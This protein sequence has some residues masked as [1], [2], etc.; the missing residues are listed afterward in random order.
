MKILEQ[1]VLVE[2][3]SSTTA[4][5]RNCFCRLCLV[6]RRKRVC[7]MTRLLQTVNFSETSLIVT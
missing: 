5:T 7:Q 2:I 3:C 6:G 4:L 1:T